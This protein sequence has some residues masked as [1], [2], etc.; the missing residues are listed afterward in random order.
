LNAGSAKASSVS[1]PSRRATNRLPASPE[2]GPFRASFLWA[3]ANC[4]IYCG[5]RPHEKPRLFPGNGAVAEVNCYKTARTCNS[6]PRGPQLKAGLGAYP[7]TIYLSGRATARYLRR[8]RASATLS[9]PECRCCARSPCRASRRTMELVGRFHGSNH[10]PTKI[11]RS[12]CGMP[13]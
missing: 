11:V 4:Y 5:G 8:P 3:S 13:G 7:R 1:A 12:S 9:P 10:L 2:W 6:R